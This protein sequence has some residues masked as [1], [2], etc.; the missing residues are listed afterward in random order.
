ME[1]SVM[2]RTLEQVRK[3]KFQFKYVS[4][5]G[6]LILV[7]I[8]SV[9]YFYPTTEPVRHD[10]GFEE[11]LG[12]WV[13]GADLP[14][15]PNNPGHHV[16]WNISRVTTVSSAGQYSLELYIDGRQ[17]D[18]TIWIMKE[19][20]VKNSSQ[21]HV[22][23]SFEFYSEQESFNVIAG[24]CA[25]AG[26][27]PP[28]VEGDFVVLGPANEVAG[29]KRYDYDETLQTGSKGEV[30]IAMGITVR[31]ETEMTYNVDDVKISIA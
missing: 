15:D 10:E 12:D 20:Q 26:S 11:G 29:W 8:L 31:W 24:V 28:T 23:L 19:I 30:W 21:I 18:G 17:D 22:S 6:A 13:K 25:Y 16:A 27:S 2:T 9:W 14:L 3:M 1:L 4:F 7:G 5:L